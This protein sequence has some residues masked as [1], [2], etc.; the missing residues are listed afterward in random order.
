MSTPD[1]RRLYALLATWPPETR[2]ALQSV[3]SAP[4][5]ERAAKIGE[6]FQQGGSIAE[7]LIDLEEDPIARVTVLT[8]LKE[9]NGR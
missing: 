4:E 6:L 3:L 9:T 1:E 7:L 5:S 2:G 8:I